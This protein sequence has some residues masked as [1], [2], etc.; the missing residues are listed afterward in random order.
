[1]PGLKRSDAA[2]VAALDVLVEAGYVGEVIA[3]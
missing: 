1:M 3:D 2:V